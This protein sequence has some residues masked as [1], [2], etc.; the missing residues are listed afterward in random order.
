M[1]RQITFMLF[2]K[3]FPTFATIL[4]GWVVGWLNWRQ[5]LPV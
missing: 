1:I 5:I 2:F 4:L 3:I